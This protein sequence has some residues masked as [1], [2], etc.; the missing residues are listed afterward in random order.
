MHKNDT[1][2]PSPMIGLK[3]SA[4]G[5]DLHTKSPGAI[6]GWYQDLE[7]HTVK[8]NKIMMEKGRRPGETLP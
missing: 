7:P 5:L 3:Q 1:L 6:G 4:N 8:N 2:L